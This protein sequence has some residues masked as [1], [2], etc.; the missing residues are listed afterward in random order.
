MFS[1]GQEF[2][3]HMT[4]ADED[5]RRAALVGEC[6]PPQS[7]DIAYL[8]R[9]HFAGTVAPEAL[10]LA[11]VTGLLEAGLVDSQ[12][13]YATIEQIDARLVETVFV[14]D[15]LELHAEVLSWNSRS[16]RVSLRVEVRN[17]H[18]LLVFV[19]TASFAIYSLP[20]QV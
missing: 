2:T 3:F 8:R 16:D 19:A 9:T 14:G 13:H 1:T 20:A 10:L 5:I 18:R 11:R 7:H 15:V 4:F 6:V 12:T 17:R